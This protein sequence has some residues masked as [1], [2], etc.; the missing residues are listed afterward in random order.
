MRLRYCQFNYSRR[1]ENKTGFRLL[2]CKHYSGEHCKVSAGESVN[3]GPAYAKLEEIEKVYIPSEITM[4]FE[5]AGFRNVEI[6]GSKPGKFLR[7]ELEPDD[8]EM[9]IVC[10][11]NRWITTE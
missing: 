5:M 7:N 6:L 1:K 11:K 2:L 3:F 4:L 8:I 10:K 9:M